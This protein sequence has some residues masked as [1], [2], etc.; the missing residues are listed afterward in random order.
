M[1]FNPEN[2]VANW[3]TFVNTLYTLTEQQVNGVLHYELK[4]KRR[5][6]YIKKLHARLTNLRQQRE[7]KEYLSCS[8]TAR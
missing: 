8:S 4:H 7:L 6:S 5:S 1:K 3:L 2:V